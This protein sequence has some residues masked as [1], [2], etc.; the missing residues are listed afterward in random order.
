MKKVLWFTLVMLFIPLIVMADIGPKPSITINLKGINS[1]DYYIDLLTKMDDS[2]YD[3]YEYGSEEF[4]YRKEPIYLYKDNGW[5]ATT[6]RN[7]FLFGKVEGNS[8]HVHRFTYFGTPDVFKVIVQ[9]PDGSIRV[10][11]TLTRTE[12]N[13]EIT[14]KEK[15]QMIKEKN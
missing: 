12:L 6:L 1:T 2:D 13:Y 15:M 9:M 8:E 7:R 5:Y 10:S 4:D 11:D 3:K 14:C